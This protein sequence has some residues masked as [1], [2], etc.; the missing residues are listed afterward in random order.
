MNTRFLA[1]FCLASPLAAQVTVNLSAAPGTV[2]LAPGVSANAWLYNG[3]LPGPVLRVSEGQ[4]LRVRFHNGL[5]EATAVHWHGQPV[6]LG[7][8]GVPDISRPAIAPGQQFTYELAN[9]RRGTYWYHPHGHEAQLDV[10]LAGVLIVDPTNP[11]DDPPF[12]VE[13]VVVL[14]DWSNTLGGAFTGHLL[15]GRT[16][17][18]QSP[19][20]VQ[21]G[22]RL[23]LRL[24]NASAVT[25][26]VVALD[27]HPM[28]V[29]HADGNRVQP[30]IVGAIPIGIGE[31]YDAIVDCTSPGVWSLAVSTIENRSA[32]VVRGIVQYAGQTQ[33]PPSASYVPPNLSSGLLLDY[34]QLAAFFAVPPITS[35]P[36]RSYTAS[37]TMGMGPG[38]MI[39]TIN[40]QVWPNVTPFQVTAGD[41]VQLAIV[42]Q[43]MM[44]MAEYH[45]MHVHGH[46]FR[47]MNTAGGA[48]QPPLKDTVLIRPTGAGS[49]V[50]VQILMDN[51]GRWLLHCHNMEHM[52]TGMMTTFEY[53]GDA[54]ADGIADRRDYEPLAAVPVVMISD[55]AGVGAMD[56]R[57]GNEPVHG[58]RRAA[59]AGG[60][61]ALRGAAPRSSRRLVLRFR[62]RQCRGPCCLRL[63]DP[64]QPGLARPA[65]RP[66][67]ARNN[68]VARRPPIVDVP[69]ARGALTRGSRRGAS[70]QR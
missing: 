65:G 42:N 23:R 21:Q 33:A 28:T 58:P 38:G 45:P 36:S 9:L 2:Q 20:M 47:L 60:N 5:P 52:A 62:D 27:A 11:Q 4:T 39:H 1:A 19:T 63:C 32:T 41:Q 64:G 6:Q 30:V 44:A 49:T 69:G 13:Q 35:T 22:Q 48:A 10:G 70:E 31:R 66:A 56:A 34:A 37:L 3:S 14:D 57:P 26:Y 17:P 29:T 24:L 46:F 59:T 18:G 68:G 67:G 25:N 51:P 54:D 8:D 12:D 53:V 40:S 15:N 55:Q 43:G 50:T 61:A 7:M 16:S